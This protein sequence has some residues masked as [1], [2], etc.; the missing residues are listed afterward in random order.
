[1]G[2]KMGKK[3]ESHDRKIRP[4][5]EYKL[6]IVVFV[7]V[8]I[9]ELIGVKKLNI[10]GTVSI[11][12]MPLLYA[13]IMGLALFLAKP[14]KF[15]QNHE[16][17]IAEGLM[18]LFMVP[19]IV[20]LALSSGQVFESLS[21]APALILQQIGNLGTIFF[22][23]P[24]ALLLGFKRES[25][26][27]T[28]SICREPNIGII[29]DK[30]GIRS[31]ETRGV[32]TVYVIG[33]IIGT[34]FI[35]L[36]ASLSTALPLHPYALAMASGIGSASMNAAAITP[37]LN[38]FPSMS[39]EILAFSGLSNLLSFCFGIYLTILVGLPLTEKLYGWLEPKIGRTTS[40]TIDPDSYEE[41]TGMK[42]HQLDKELNKL[43]LKR[44]IDWVM[45]L[46]IFS[47][48]V[49]IGNYISTGEPWQTTLIGMLILS[50]I[51]YISYLFERLLPKHISS[52]VWASAI[53]IILSLPFLP[54]ADY[55]LQFVNAV[56]LSAIVTVY[57]AYVGISIGRDWDQF[58][59]LGWRGAIVTCFV[60]LGTYLCSATIADI[61][62]L[63]TG[64][65]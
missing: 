56:D 43:S 45:L 30:Y 6:H 50:A 23:M 54:T 17:K 37:L 33:T 52:I 21:F 19:I 27:M 34:V 48:M 28:S 59:K 40:S 7:L 5:M 25:I 65:I 16:S 11:V 1:M 32:L 49:T 38:I 46:L 58:K 61:V 53:G 2:Y 12:L 51:S 13:M 29:L 31:P 64:A 4:W 63:F 41:E 57:L 24:V 39:H 55:I 20:K 3:K 47:I 14:V 9:A 18:I 44:L 22:A 62:L 35:S 8:V 15:I 10:T 36:V 26:G 60:I 42:N